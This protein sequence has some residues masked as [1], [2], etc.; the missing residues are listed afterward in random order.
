MALLD[1]CFYSEVLGMETGVKVILPLGRK[2]QD[3]AAE[4][5]PTPVLYLLH[6]LSEDHTAWTRRTALE[7]YILKRNL[8]VVMPAAGR[9]FYINMHSGGRYFD[10]I[11][12]EL[13]TVMQQMFPI[14]SKREDCFIAGLSMGGYGALK[15][16]LTF[17]ESFA[18]G[19]SLSGAVDIHR[20][21]RDGA[22]LPEIEAVFGKTVQPENDLRYLAQT[23]VSGQRMPALYQYCG[24]ADF[25]W[26]DNR[27]F[28]DFIQPLCRDYTYREDGKGHE[29]DA[30]EEQLVHVLDWIQERNE[31]I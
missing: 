25:L 30:W 26:E 12:Q 11:T 1:C 18:G 15:A 4:C 27:S 3:P 17:P 7:R 2:G 22:E 19:A 21:F 20:V 5:R 29:W 14:S 28:R 10:Y 9:S 6:G 16:A 24:N 31:H 8:A 13:P 23:A